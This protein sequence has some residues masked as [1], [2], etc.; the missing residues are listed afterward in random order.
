MK[1][2]MHTDTKHTQ[3]VPHACFACCKAYHLVVECLVYLVNLDVSLRHVGAVDVGQALS[4]SVLLRK[5]GL[6]FLSIDDA[7]AVLS[8]KTKS[9]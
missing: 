9:I 8:E 3:M 7:F 5:A 1:I 6:A 4:L 2:S